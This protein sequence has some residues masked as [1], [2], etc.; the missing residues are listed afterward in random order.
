MTKKKLFIKKK[1]YKIANLIGS[2][3]KKIQMS[4]ENYAKMILL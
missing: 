2:N 1:C 4:F 3:L